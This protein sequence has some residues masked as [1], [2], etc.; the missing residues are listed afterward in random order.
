[1]NFMGNGAKPGQMSVTAVMLIQEN[2]VSGE[3]TARR[4]HSCGN[5]PSGASSPAP[6]PCAPIAT[7]AKK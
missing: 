5:L 2:N 7:P 6:S 4:F 3:A 1:M